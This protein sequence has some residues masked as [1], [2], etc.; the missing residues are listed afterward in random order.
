MAQRNTETGRGDQGPQ[1]AA[2]ATFLARH[3]YLEPPRESG[4]ES[5]AVPAFDG[6]VE[7]AVGRYERL[8]ARPETGVLD[9][10]TIR[11]M[12]TPRCGRADLRGGRESGAVV[13]PASGW[14]R[15]DIT[16]NA[17]LTQDLPPLGAAIV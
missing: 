12:N 17:D 14:G 15:R 4:R 10:E 2:L 16:F 9:A 3:G 8:H 5:G 1:V 11:W 6:G 7:A 13:G